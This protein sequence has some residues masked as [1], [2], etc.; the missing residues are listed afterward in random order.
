MRNFLIALV[1]VLILSPLCYGSSLFTSCASA[2][3]A[4]ANEKAIWTQFGGKITKIEQSSGNTKGLHYR[5]TT[6]DN[7]TERIFEAT[8][9]WQ[10]YGP[11]P[12]AGHWIVSN[13]VTL[14]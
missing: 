8:A 14:K 2:I 11:T 6:D 7:G 1:A 4:I 10:D 13:V 3:E 12:G 9:T 5:F